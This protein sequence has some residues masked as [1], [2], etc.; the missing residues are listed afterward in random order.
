MHVEALLASLGARFRS[1]FSVSGGRSGRLACSSGITHTSRPFYRN[2]FRL[3]KLSRF[4]VT[5]PQRRR[6][7]VDV[8]AGGEDKE[9]P[10]TPRLHLGA[11]RLRRGRA[12][13]RALRTSVLRT[14]AA[15]RTKAS[16]AHVSFPSRLPP[17]PLFPPWLSPVPRRRP[18]ARRPSSTPLSATQGAHLSRPA[19]R[20]APP[21][22][23]RVPQ[24]PS[25]RTSLRSST[26]TAC[27]TPP[28]SA[29]AS[30][31]GPS[32]SP[33]WR[34]RPRTPRLPAPRAPCCSPPTSVGVAV[35]GD[36]TP[37]PLPNGR[38]NPAPSSSGSSRSPSSPQGGHTATTAGQ[39]ARRAAASAARRRA[40]RP[41]SVPCWQRDLCIDGA[42]SASFPSGSGWAHH[43]VTRKRYHFILP[44]DNEAGAP[45]RHGT[46]A[47]PRSVTG[48]TNVDNS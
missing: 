14:G 20:R 28:P 34:A 26:S 9:V 12:P 48:A 6:S 19:P 3:A 45:P 21:T 38:A 47:F 29:R 4:I 44:R 15:W 5:S 35:G 36:A 10:R 7:P 40:T 2:C 39:S 11:G 46:Y 32:P 33:T 37:T 16:D 31:A 27:A 25:A 24:A 42:A 23:A 41:H 17:T 30:P 22:R 8:P 1:E 18:P 43:P 13:W